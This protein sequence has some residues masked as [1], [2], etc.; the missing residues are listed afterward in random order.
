[1]QDS[2]M[3][4]SAFHEPDAPAR[5]NR[6]PRWRFGLMSVGVHSYCDCLELEASAPGGMR[7]FPGANILSSPSRIALPP[8]EFWGDAS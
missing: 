6:L 1:M 5:A 3:A 4:G 7:P 8:A 2:R